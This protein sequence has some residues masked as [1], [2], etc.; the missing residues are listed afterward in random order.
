MIKPEWKTAPEWANYVAMDACGKWFWFEN[1]PV[2]DAAEKV[3]RPNQGKNAEA[4]HWTET[5][6]RRRAS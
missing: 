4:V 3:W 2:L 5:S 6:E 1:E